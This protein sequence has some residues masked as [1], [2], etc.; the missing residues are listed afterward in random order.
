MPLAVGTYAGLAALSDGAGLLNLAWTQDERPRLAA[1]VMAVAA[2]ELADEAARQLPYLGTYMV[3]DPYGEAEF[4]PA[5]AGFFGRPGWS[6]GVTCGP[7]VGPLLHGLSLLAVNGTVAVATDVYPDFPHWTARVRGRCVGYRAQAQAAR[8]AV[9]LLERPALL[10]DGFADLDDVRALC[11]R[12]A[13]H[14]GVVVVDES[15]ANYRE[16]GYSA[17]LLAP[18]TDNLVVVRGLSK[19]YGLG[20]LRF[21]YCVSSAAATERVRA[22]V[23][24]L[25]ASSVSLRIARRVLELGD[26]AGPLRTRIAEHRPEALALLADAGV[27][28][29]EAAAPGL[30]Y[31][32][33]PH[34]PER[35]LESLAA[36]GVQGKLHPF[37]SAA[38]EGAGYAGRISVPLEP[39]RLAEF[40]ARMRGIPGAGQALGNAGIS[41][42]FSVETD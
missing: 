36:R 22:V 42:A 18:E 34:E 16:P 30:P 8:A 6:A 40:A 29:A 3:R 11:G 31:V 41:S 37:W 28:G 14:G 35:A 25:G 9:V 7:G 27:S 17:A 12:V 1:D 2:A 20:G 39:A 32:L 38:A 19:A 10:R 15:N 26:I 4:G 13:R 33:F 23:P 24:P 21:G 5:V